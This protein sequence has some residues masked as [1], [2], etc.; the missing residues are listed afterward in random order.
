MNLFEAAQLGQPPQATSIR[1]A[2]VCTGLKL[3][4]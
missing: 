2:V 3:E 4:G 1:C